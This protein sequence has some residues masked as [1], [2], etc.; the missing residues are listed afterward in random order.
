MGTRPDGSRRLDQPERTKRS[1]AISMA[2]GELGMFIGQLY[3]KYDLTRVEMMAA[4]AE[5]LNG[6]AHYEI[7]DQWGGE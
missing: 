4:V 7:R 5:N 2:S 3:K 6:M 1:Q